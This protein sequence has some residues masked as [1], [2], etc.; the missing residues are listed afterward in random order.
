M[1]ELTGKVA[2]RE[3]LWKTVPRGAQGST[4][5]VVDGKMLD[6]AWR[7]DGD[8]LW[9]ELAGGLSGFD[10]QGELNDDGRMI[11]QVTR[12]G[13]D[14]AWSG[15]SYLRAGELEASAS[16]GGA[17]KGVRVRA[18]M[19]GKIIRILVKSGQSVEK[20][21]PILVMEAMKMENEIRAPQAGRIP[22]VK[23]TEGQ[24]VETG[25]DLCKID[26]I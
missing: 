5:V 19:P 8:G 7:R 26:P 21:Q 18:Q 14:E 4:Q 17:K 12:R 24:A 16:V 20:D 6:V 13:S 3:L 23:V 15:L 1:S 2:K 25:A 10:F 9:L 11:Y 22:E